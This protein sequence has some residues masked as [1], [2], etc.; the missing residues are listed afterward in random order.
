MARRDDGDGF[1]VVEGNARFE[2]RQHFVERLCRRAAEGSHGRADLRELRARAGVDSVS[3]DRG[4]GWDV[5]V[6]VVFVVD[7]QVGA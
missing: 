2:H 6:L 5:V 4:L 7:R 3:R 1:G